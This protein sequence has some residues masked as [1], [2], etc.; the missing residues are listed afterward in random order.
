VAIEIASKLWKMPTPKLADVI[1]LV[2]PYLGG[3]IL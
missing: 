1:N 3:F 2:R